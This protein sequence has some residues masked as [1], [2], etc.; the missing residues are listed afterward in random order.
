MDKSVGIELSETKASDSKNVYVL[1]PH[2]KALQVLFGVIRR[3]DITAKEFV[4][5]ADRLMRILAEEGLAAL[6]M[7]LPSWEIKT[8]TGAKLVVPK[9][10]D[11]TEICAVSILR[12]GDILLEAVRSVCPGVSVGKILIQRDES[13]PEKRPK[14]Y[15][16]KFPKDIVKKQVL[17]CDPML[18]SSSYLLQC[19]YMLH[20]TIQY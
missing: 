14:L 9:P 16:S 4:A 5:Y 6:S 3:D 10:I 15:Y 2:S 19:I 18:V 7:A 1:F 13:D 11:P 17:L 20:D 12:S 8:P